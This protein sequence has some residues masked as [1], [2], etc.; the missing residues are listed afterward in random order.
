MKTVLDGCR[1]PFGFKPQGFSARV[2][3]KVSAEE[4]D[5][6]PLGVKMGDPAGFL[7]LRNYFDSFT[8]QAEMNFA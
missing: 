4:D 1:D 6:C 3:Q 8:F 2:L 5:I 7:I